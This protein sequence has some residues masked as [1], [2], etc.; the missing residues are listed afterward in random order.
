MDPLRIVL[1]LGLVLHKFLW[2]FLK[3]RSKAYKSPSPS[4]G[5]VVKWLIKPLKMFVLAFILIQTL[6]LD[7][8]PIAQDPYFLRICGTLIYF[9]GLSSAVLGRVQLGK[10]WVDLEDYQVL[11]EQS[12]TTHGIYRYIRHPIYSGDIFLLT[13]LQLALNSWLVVMVFAFLLV[14]VKQALAEERLL[15]RVFP[16][17]GA[18]CRSTKRFIPFIA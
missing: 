4:Q 13:G 12:L 6:F 7:L 3:W 2:E 17:Y 18:Y 8:L 15:A 5:S 14:T 1:F 9:I 10:N 16:N 11:P